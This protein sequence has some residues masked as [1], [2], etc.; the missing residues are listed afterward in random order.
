MY[1]CVH[2]VDGLTCLLFNIDL[3]EDTKLGTR[4]G[5]HSTLRCVNFPPRW[6]SCINSKIHEDTMMCSGEELDELMPR[7]DVENRDAGDGELQQ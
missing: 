7:D 4:N 3:S 5:E 2:V 1:K 6:W